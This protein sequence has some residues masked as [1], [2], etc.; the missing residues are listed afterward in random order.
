MFGRSNEKYL[1]HKVRLTLV[2]WF[3]VVYLEFKVIGFLK[4]KSD[5]SKSRYVS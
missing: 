4:T 5:V 3:E 2:N 1:V